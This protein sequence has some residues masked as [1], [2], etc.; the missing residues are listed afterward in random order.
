M[1]VMDPT[2]HVTVSRLS[3]GMI[4]LCLAYRK[5]MLNATWRTAENIK[6][7]PQ[8]NIGRIL[9]TQANNTGN[10]DS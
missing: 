5:N 3:I 6:L 4:T 9:S 10:V 2:S 8:R 7:T 1:S